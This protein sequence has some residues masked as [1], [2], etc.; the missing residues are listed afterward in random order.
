MLMCA[1][2]INSLTDMIISLSFFNWLRALLLMLHWSVVPLQA[3]QS[4]TG[5]TEVWLH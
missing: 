2:L 3:V 1:D 4:V 5:A